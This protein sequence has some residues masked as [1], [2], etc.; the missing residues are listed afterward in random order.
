MTESRERTRTPTLRGP[1]EFVLAPTRPSGSTTPAARKAPGAPPKDTKGYRAM[2]RPRRRPCP[3][4]P[5]SPMWL[6]PSP[7]SNGV[8]LYEALIGS[9]PVIDEDTGLFHHVVW[10]LGGQTALG[11]H[12]FPDPH[13]SVLSTNAG[14]AWT[15]WRSPAAVA[16]NSRNGSR[17][18][19]SWASRTVAS[20]THLTDRAF[21]FGIPTTSRWSS[22]PRPGARGSRLLIRRIALGVASAAATIPPRPPSRERR[23]AAPPER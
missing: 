20:S 8:A 18:S 21:R 14:P 16:A 10:L 7:T 22:S 3:N 9:P 17:S 1:Q 11:I 12:Q 23:M 6:S 13:G 19:T 4:S 5:A 15:T 2:T